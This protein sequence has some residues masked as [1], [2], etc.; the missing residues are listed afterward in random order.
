MDRRLFLK[1]SV[2]CLIT[3]TGI[4]ILPKVM[5]QSESPE[6]QGSQSLDLERWLFETGKDDLATEIYDL[7]SNELESGYRVFLPLIS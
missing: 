7:V 6:V 1:G 4:V 5:S 3:A 2:A